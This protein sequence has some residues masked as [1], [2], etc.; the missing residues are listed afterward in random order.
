MT[1][2]VRK[3]PDG[4]AAHPLVE[5]TDRTGE[6]AAQLDDWLSERMTWWQDNTDIE[7]N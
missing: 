6:A 4:L 3:T 5:V 2:A 1:V 7:E